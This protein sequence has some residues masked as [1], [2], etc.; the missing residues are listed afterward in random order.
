MRLT[1]ELGFDGS[2][3]LPGAACLARDLDEARRREVKVLLASI[4]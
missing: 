4:A 2:S 3:W 1:S